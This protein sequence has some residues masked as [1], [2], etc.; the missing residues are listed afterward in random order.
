[1]APWDWVSATCSFVDGIRIAQCVGTCR[2]PH[3]GEEMNQ[4]EYRSKEVL[5]AVYLP[6]R[7]GRILRYVEYD[8]PLACTCVRRD[9]GRNGHNNSSANNLMA[10]LRTITKVQKSSCSCES[11][12]K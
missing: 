12:K 3:T 4:Q 11:K 2:D 7:H 9:N 10:H 5:Y 8:I 1:M 6:V